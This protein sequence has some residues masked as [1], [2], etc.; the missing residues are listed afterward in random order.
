MRLPFSYGLPILR[1]DFRLR[2]IL[3]VRIWLLPPICFIGCVIGSR[4]EHLCLGYVMCLVH[5]MF[6][7]EV[8]QLWPWGISTHQMFVSEVGLLWSHG[9]WFGLVWGSIR[10][11]FLKWIPFLFV[12][13]DPSDFW[14]LE[15]IPWLFMVDL[16]W[17]PSEFG[18]WSGSHWCRRQNL[19]LLI[20]F[21][22][23]G[24][25]EAWTPGSWLPWWTI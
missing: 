14:F 13:W 21:Q 20:S 9:L 2:R 3:A 17:D 18:F 8:D 7:S 11:W 10:L 5:Q 6:V 16:V 1:R 22:H 15:W 23:E 12:G 24:V 19:L 4:E 25:C